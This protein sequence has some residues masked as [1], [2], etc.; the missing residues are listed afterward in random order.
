M[1][2]TDDSTGLD[3][4]YTE[5]T[6]V[7]FEAGTLTTISNCADEVESRLKR[8]TL[9]ATSIPTLTQV[10]NWLVVAKQELAQYK[11][12]TWRRRYVTA[13]T[14]ASQYR[15][16]L[17]PDY[18]GGRT[19]LRDTTNDRGIVIWLDHWFDTKY[20]DPS[21]ET[22]GEPA[23]ATI[24]N[25]ELWLCPPP[26]GV[27]TLELEYER[28]GD[29]QTQTD[30]S[31]LPQLERFHCCDFATF[32][33]FMSLHRFEE[34]GMYE[35]LW[36]KAIGKSIKADGRKRWRSMNYQMIDCFTEYKAR[37]NQP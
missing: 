10:N 16:A 30:F 27:Y 23:V 37:Q 36:D 28:S 24:K 22:S 21:A 29:D 31:W 3:T 6:V 25:M 2:I 15:Y 32:R 26:D 4:A 5:Q 9:S 33:A 1:S 7:A 20:P 11:G 18:Q 35:R 13:S 34:A 12:F 14:V 19:S 17:P 8:G